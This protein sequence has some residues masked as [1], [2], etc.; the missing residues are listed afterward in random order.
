MK[1]FKIFYYLFYQF[2]GQGRFI[3][4]T[5]TLEAWGKEQAIKKFED[6]GLDYDNFTIE[7]IPM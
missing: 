6:L 3:T 1:K 5:V 2:N 4:D 7:E